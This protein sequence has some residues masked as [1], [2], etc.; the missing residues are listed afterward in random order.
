L[1]ALAIL[2]AGLVGIA[3]LIQRD[4]RRP[5]TVRATAPAPISAWPVSGAPLWPVPESPLMHQD[6][7]TAV[8]DPAPLRVF[9]AQGSITRGGEWE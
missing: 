6:P 8:V 5:R 3:W 9:L 7:V 2:A 4:R 1:I